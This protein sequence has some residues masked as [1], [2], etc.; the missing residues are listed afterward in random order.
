MTNESFSL[1]ASLSATNCFMFD[2]G[3]S[4]GLGVLTK[5]GPTTTASA[6]SGGLDAF[7]RIGAETNTVLH[8]TALGTVNGPA[9]LRGNLN[10]R[11]V[12]LRYNPSA[13]GQWSAAV[14]LMPGTNTLTVFADHPSSQFTTNKVSTFTV[15]SGACDKV[16]SLFDGGGYVTNRVWKNSQGQTVRS[17]A[18]IWDAFGHLV[19]VSERDTNTNGFNWQADLDPLGRR[20]RTTTVPVTNGEALAAQPR[21]LVHFYDPAVEFLE[22]GVA[23]NGVVT[24]KNYGPDLDGRYG[25]QQGLGGLESLTTGN[26]IVGIVQDCFGNVLGRA[27]NGVMTWNTAR[28]SLFGPADGYPGLSLSVGPLTSEHLAWRGK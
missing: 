10:G 24:W 8:R 21:T 1:G 18:L 23:I 12:D 5:A 14:E 4:G 22:I 28:S 26:S 2:N 19:K 13:A 16:D 25:G 7:S 9:S 17:Q 11:P 3:A 20:L 15:D 6:W 27:N